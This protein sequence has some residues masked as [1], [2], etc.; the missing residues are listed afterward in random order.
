MRTKITVS[1]VGPSE[2]LSGGAD[3]L[4][5]LA[6]NGKSEDIYLTYKPTVIAAAIVGAVLDVDVDE[7]VIQYKGE[8][9]PAYKVTWLHTDDE[10]NNKAPAQSGTWREEKAAEVIGNLLVGKVITDKHKLA[11]KLYKWL[12]ASLIEG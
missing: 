7:T 3:K 1:E 9:T 12:E 8:R 10:G 2:H 5:F 4:I 11:K 6:E